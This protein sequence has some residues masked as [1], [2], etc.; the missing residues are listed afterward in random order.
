MIWVMGVLCL[1]AGWSAFC[2]LKWTQ[3]AER[4]EEMCAID[5]AEAE[6]ALADMRTVARGEAIARKSALEASQA[7]LADCLVCL[8]K[9]RELLKAVNAS[10][11]DCRAVSI[12]FTPCGTA[13]V[14]ADGTCV[15]SGFGQL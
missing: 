7:N 6:R 15:T 9:C 13:S 12:P 5:R 14:K 8:E 10:L 2:S 3:R 1:L 4:A 11:P